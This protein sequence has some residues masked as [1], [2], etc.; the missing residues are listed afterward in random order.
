MPFTVLNGFFFFP[1]N[2]NLLPQT[3]KRNVAGDAP[4]GSKPVLPS[5]KIMQ[6]SCMMIIILFHDCMG[7]GGVVWFCQTFESSKLS[8]IQVIRG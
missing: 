7:V 4:R 1:D 2:W 8:P 3:L 5:G 6:F